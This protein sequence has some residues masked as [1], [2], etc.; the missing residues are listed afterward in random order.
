M[1]DQEDRKSFIQHLV[2]TFGCTYICLWLYWPLPSN[3]LRFFDGLCQKD[4]DNR[5]STSS[6][7]SLALTLFQEYKASAFNLVE[8]GGVPGLAFKNNVPYL[9]LKKMDLQRLASLATQSQFY[10]VARIKTAIFMGCRSGEVE[11]GFSNEPQVILC[12]PST[13]VN[14]SSNY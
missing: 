1:L 13:Y 11:L 4:D 3:C 9:E 10:Q 6:T 12:V 7:G 5:P 8:N 14:P 2:H